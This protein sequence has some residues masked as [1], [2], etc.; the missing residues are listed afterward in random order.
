VSN[1]RIECDARHVNYVGG[2][3]LASVP[4]GRAEECVTALRSAGY[5]RAAVIGHVDE[6]IK[7]ADSRPISFVGLHSD[8]PDGQQKQDFYE[9]VIL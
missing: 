2:G 6:P 9:P 4:S 5:D 3:L 8:E 1:E 7:D